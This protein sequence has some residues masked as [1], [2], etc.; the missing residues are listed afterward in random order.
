MENMTLKIHPGTHDLVLDEAGALSMIGGAETVAQCVRTT[1]EVFKGEWFLNLEHGTD[2]EQILGDAQGDPETVLREA[3][4]QE[5][6]VQYID[7]IAVSH[8]GR[9][10]SIAFS[11]RLKDGTSITVEASA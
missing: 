1:L 10:L 4:F 6:E 11:G 2:Y 3:I 5:T 7:S 9:E 8:E